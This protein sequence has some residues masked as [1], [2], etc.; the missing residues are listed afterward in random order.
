M[1]NRSTDRKKQSSQN[2][3]GKDSGKKRRESSRNVPDPD[4][5]FYK[6]LV[7]PDWSGW[8]DEE[9]DEIIE[10]AVLYIAEAQRRWGFKL[11]MAVG[12]WLYRELYRMND[13]YLSSQ[14]PGKTRSLYDI[15][16]RTNRSPKTLRNWVWAARMKF[17]LA[18]QGYTSERLML[19]HW[20]A[21][22][23][24]RETPLAAR[25]VAQ[26]VHDENPDVEVVI[27]YVRKWT[28][29]KKEP[30][31][32]PKKKKS[33]KRKRRK[34]PYEQQLLN[35]MRLVHRWVVEVELSPHLR[36]RLLAE[37]GQIRALVEK[38]AQA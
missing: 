9:L 38:G 14:D 33:G 13:A 31:P 16:R 15:A 4:P 18:E 10:R 2:Q 21:L 30:P 27:Q 26:W 11:G 19:S 5:H 23:P 29:Y 20:A 36:E 12:E 1:P 24:L 7:D 8:T 22:Y 35:V 28:K 25:K 17:R 32:P 37:V 3:Q 34:R 6:I